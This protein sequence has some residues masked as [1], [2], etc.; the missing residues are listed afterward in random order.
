MSQLHGNRLAAVSLM[1]RL[2]LIKGTMSNDVS[3]PVNLPDLRKNRVELCERS[4]GETRGQAAAM[5]PNYSDN[6]PCPDVRC[7]S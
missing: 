6:L 5:S 3:Q 2:K 1:F 7:A 4:R